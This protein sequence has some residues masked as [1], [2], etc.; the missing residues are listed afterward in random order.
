MSTKATMPYMES[1]THI[2]HDPRYKRLS[3]S[4]KASY[5]ELGHLSFRI[6]GGGTFRIEGEEE[7]QLSIDDIAR[8]L[9]L[10]STEMNKD[11]DELLAAKLIHVNGRGPEI[12]EFRHPVKFQEK[13]RADG[14][15]RTEKSRSGKKSSD[16]LLDD[17]V[18]SY[19]PVTDAYKSQESESDK[20]SESE[21]ES[22]SVVSGQTD[23]RSKTLTLLCSLEGI[24]K[25]NLQLILDD[26]L[27]QVQDLLAM[28]A[29]L[30]DPVSHCRKPEV[31]AP[32]NLLKHEHIGSRRKTKYYTSAAWTR[33]LPAGIL[34]KLGLCP[35]EA[36]KDGEDIS[37]SGY[38]QNEVTAKVAAFFGGR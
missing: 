31:L 13:W 1:P 10:T 17:G 9:N 32:K 15:A 38:T 7:D 19:T 12:C 35:S 23:D 2:V 16:K 6:D 5:W 4:A 28:L 21:E 33:H 11:L 37:C 18:T 30:H 14:A 25:T 34:A 26:P 36:G 8:E 29:Y 24:S 22:L 27:I 3:R 20:E